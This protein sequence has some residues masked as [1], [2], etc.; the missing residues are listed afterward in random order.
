MLLLLKLLNPQYI[1]FEKIIDGG[2]IINIIKYPEI[3][4]KNRIEKYKLDNRNEL[5]SS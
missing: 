5:E 4:L 3:I 2:I 1:Q